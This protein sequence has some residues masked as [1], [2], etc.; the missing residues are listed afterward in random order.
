MTSSTVFFFA[1]FFIFYKC[2]NIV[3]REVTKF[4][5]LTP[6]LPKLFFSVMT[7]LENKKN[8][9]LPIDQ[10]ID[11]IFIKPW[12]VGKLVPKLKLHLIEK[13][14]LRSC[15]FLFM[16]V[17]HW[18]LLS[19]VRRE[20]QVSACSNSQRFCYNDNGLQWTI[21]FGFVLFNCCVVL[22]EYFFS[23][24]LKVCPWVHLPNMLFCFLNSSF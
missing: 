8:V 19:T 5:E 20:M 1:F 21:N 18:F 15:V 10:Q 7:P 14:I 9:M 4:I 23:S 2:C 22:G 24:V 17:S 13:Q 12:Q 6:V 3:L 16:H 11:W